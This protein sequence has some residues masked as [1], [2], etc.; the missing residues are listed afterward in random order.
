MSR[1]NNL[2][3]KNEGGGR[4]SVLA[5]LA[6][7]MF[8]QG[9]S[10]GAPRTKRPSGLLKEALS[11]TVGDVYDRSPCPHSLV[12]WDEIDDPQRPS[13][14]YRRR[15]RRTELS[16]ERPAAHVGERTEAAR[17]H[18]GAGGRTW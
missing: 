9:W 12:A 15:T 16:C 7:R 11:R 13:D 10:V 2:I 6:S 3:A 5:R 1:E 8:G 17:L 14:P 4:P 18:A